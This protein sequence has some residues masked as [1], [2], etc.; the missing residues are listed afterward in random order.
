MTEPLRVDDQ[1]AVRTLTLDRPQARNALSGALV[2]ALY[3]AR[4]DA[5]PDPGVRVVV[6]G[7]GLTARP[8]DGAAG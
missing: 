5:D 2:A 8:P 6:L 7:G 1:G 4:L 3:G